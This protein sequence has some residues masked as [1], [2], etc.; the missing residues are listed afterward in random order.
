MSKVRYG[1]VGIGRMGS[2]HAKKLLKGL[3][4]NATLTAVSDTG[5]DRRDWAA[6]E[7]KGVAVYDDYNQ[8]LAD[9]NVDV[10]VV[11]TPHY[12]HP[13]IGVAALKAGK[14]LL[15]EKP[16][17]VYTKAVRE[18]IAESEKHPSQVFGIMLNQRTN[19]LYRAARTIIENGELG[20]LKRVNWI[21]TN[22]YR[23]QAYYDLGGWRG[24]WA[25]E[26]GGVLMNQA[27]H[28]LDLFQ[29]L[30]GMPVSIRANCVVGVGRKINVENDVTIIAR[31]A[32]G[33]SGVFV[34]STHDAPGSN[35]LEIDGTGGRLVIEQNGLTEKMTFDKLPS[36][37][38]ELN[39]K[40]TSP[41]PFIRAKKTTKRTGALSN[42]LVLG[43]V[44]QH[45]GIFR[46]FS[47]AVLFGEPLIAPGADGIKGLTIANAAYLSSWLGSDVD[48]PF[49]E[50]LYKRELDKRIAEEAAS[51]VKK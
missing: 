47:R 9:P 50:D 13:V 42:A 17:G 38:T 19:P 5:A 41:M 1:I 10:V 27:P 16:A 28:Q 40:V 51:G 7:L 14:H 25:G 31:Y 20:E 39:A 18:L 34:S 4:K 49:D 32:N 22:W 37:E 2:T 24:T 46:N 11:S 43:V 30:G 3:D 12:D 21:I 36:L 26:G 33:A 48:I 23:P 29:W 8:L 35:R 15:I 44:G 6:K 45:M